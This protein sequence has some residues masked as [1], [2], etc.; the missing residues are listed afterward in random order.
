MSDKNYN[1]NCRFAAEIVSYL[2]DE[3]ETREKAVFETH[4]KGCLSC[5]DE[6]ADFSFARFAVKDWRDEEFSHLKTPSFEIPFDV[7]Q[8]KESAATNS[9]SL[10][11]NLR[12]IFSLHPVWATGAATL[13]I[14][15][16]LA[17]SA[18]NLFQPDFTAKN[19][20]IN[21]VNVSVSPAKNRVEKT[22]P[23]IPVES[24]TAYSSEMITTS[25]KN[26]AP[27]KPKTTQKAR[28]MEIRKNSVVKVSNREQKNINAGKNVENIAASE[29]RNFNKSTKGATPV[30]RQIPTLNNFDVEVDNT[31]RLAELFEDIDTKK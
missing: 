24:E 11:G 30:N 3:I 29:V 2:Y 28:A 19:D 27:E 1:S 5:A 4:L 6:L 15:I 10:F 26:D 12:R 23:V 16:G 18:T 8:T 9:D 13:I 20:D 17:F 31:L 22:V 25:I 21:S 7:K 14:M